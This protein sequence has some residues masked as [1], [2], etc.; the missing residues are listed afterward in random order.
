MTREEDDTRQS[1]N[2]EGKRRVPR[3]TKLLA[4]VGA[5]LGAA[6]VTAVGM[7]GVWVETVQKDGTNVRLRVVNRTA[8]NFDSGWH[9][10]PGPAIVQVQKGSLQITQG[11]CTP[12]TVGPG[13][14]YIEQP[15]VP[16]RAVGLGELQWTTS[17]I[18]L[19][20]DEV[21][22]ALSQGPCP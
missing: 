18:T 11:S 13:E 19:Y 10:H 3:S 21:T 16:V 4:L 9:T 2:R 6:V 5:V 20:N 15:L 12:K 8:G 7:S 22:T 17:F 1:I 14:T